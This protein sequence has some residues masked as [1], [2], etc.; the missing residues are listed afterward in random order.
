M[1]VLVITGDPDRL[2]FG[3]LDVN[4]GVGEILLT[5]SKGR[6]TGCPYSGRCR[7]RDS[8]MPAELA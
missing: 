3:N 2:K 1:A 4:G 7:T 6:C 8:V 5:A